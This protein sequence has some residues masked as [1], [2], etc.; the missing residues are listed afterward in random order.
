MQSADGQTLPFVDGDDEPP[1]VG[2]PKQMQM[3]A[4][5]PAFHESGA[6]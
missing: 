6:V 5:L 2:F 4:A 3:A 1:S